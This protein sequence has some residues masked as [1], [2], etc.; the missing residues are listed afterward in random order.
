MADDSSL[1]SRVMI[2]VGQMM[3]VKCL[4]AVQ[5]ILLVYSTVFEK[6]CL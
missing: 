2:A 4:S 6:S 5:F 1:K 3:Y